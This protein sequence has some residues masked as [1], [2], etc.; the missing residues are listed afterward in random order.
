MPLMWNPCAAFTMIISHLLR[1][2]MTTVG[3]IIPAFLY[4][5]SSLVDSKPSNIKSIMYD[6]AAV[7]DL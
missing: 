2:E 4:Q 7:S 1:L 3:I 5:L 6:M